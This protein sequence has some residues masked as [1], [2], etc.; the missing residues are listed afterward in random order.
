MAINAFHWVDSLAFNFGVIQ[1]AAVAFYLPRV[2]LGLYQ[3]VVIGVFS[4]IWTVGLVR[5]FQQEEG[6]V[7][8]SLFDDMD[9][10]FLHRGAD[11]LR[12]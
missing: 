9:P 10:F 7:S 2:R 4:T 6:R 12:L 8:R 1:V 5:V 3:L 11:L